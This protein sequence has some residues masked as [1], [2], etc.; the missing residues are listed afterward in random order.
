MN[1][2]PPPTALFWAQ[3]ACREG[4]RKEAWLRPG[5]RAR[6]PIPTPCTVPM[7]VVCE[8]WF[9]V[10]QSRLSPTFCFRV[11]PGPTLEAV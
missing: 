11:A 3:T 2:P 1:T 10:A 7:P 9:G 4:G 8:T 5:L 6:T